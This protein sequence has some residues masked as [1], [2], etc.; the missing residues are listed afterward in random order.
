[1]GAQDGF[2]QVKNIEGSS[3]SFR[4][5]KFVVMEITVEEQVQDST[6]KNRMDYSFI[7]FMTTRY[8]SRTISERFL[9]LRTRWNWLYYQRAL[10]LR[11][12]W[13]SIPAQNPIG[14]LKLA[15]SSTVREFSTRWIR[16]TWSLKEPCVEGP[17]ITEELSKSFLC[18]ARS[19]SQNHPQV[20]KND[21]STFFDFDK[22]QQIL[23]RF[24][25]TDQLIRER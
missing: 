12:L 11:L 2:E 13:Y 18:F 5:R 4:L 9:T 1:M 10:A 15:K 24:Q 8:L 16:T 6:Y 14:L 22:E 23:K 20:W 25:I 7:P 21:F 19:N 3:E 17:L